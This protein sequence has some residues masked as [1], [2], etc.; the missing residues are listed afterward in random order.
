VVARKHI[1]E[2]L[3]QNYDGNKQK[4]VDEL[5]SYMESI[6]LLHQPLNIRTPKAY[7]P[8]DDDDDDDDVEEHQDSI[9]GTEPARG[10][11][12]SIDEPETLYIPTDD[13]HN[14]YNNNN[15]KRKYRGTENISN[16]DNTNITNINVTNNTTTKSLYR[17]KPISKKHHDKRPKIANT[18]YRKRKVWSRQEDQVLRSKAQQFGLKWTKIC[19]F[20]SDRDGQDCRDRWRNLLKKG[21]TE[22]ELLDPNYV[23]GG[24]DGDEEEQQQPKDDNNKDGNLNKNNI[25]KPPSIDNS[26]T[27]SPS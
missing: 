14:L 9:N 13:S 26:P 16:N 8:S 17:T 23:I 5:L 27:Y 2:L 18:G 1:K 20:L 4:I 25:H 10:D 19:A 12:I 7:Y 15:R 21:F 11:N 22:G 6:I 24:V 3:S